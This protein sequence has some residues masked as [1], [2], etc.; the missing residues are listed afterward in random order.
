[1]ERVQLISAF[2]FKRGLVYLKRISE[3]MG[4][5]AAAQERV[6]PSVSK[7]PKAAEFGRTTVAELNDA[8][9]KEHPFEW[10]KI[11]DRQE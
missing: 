7:T 3:Y 1:M 11:Q 6:S 2:L 5:I 9:A 10:E 4:R 8:Y